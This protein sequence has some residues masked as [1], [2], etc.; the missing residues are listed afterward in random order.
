MSQETVHYAVEGRVASV[1]LGRPRYRNAQSWRM[2]DELDAALDHAQQ[3]QGVRAIIVT[4][5]GDHFSSGH[6]LGHLRAARGPRG[7]RCSPGGDRGVRRLSQVQPR[8]HAQVAQPAQADHRHGARLLHLRRLDDRGS[9]MDRRL[10]G[11]GAPGSWPAIRGVL[12][13]PLGHRT[14]A[15]PR[16]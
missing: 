12:L 13:H 11:A 2:L 16:S 6:D 8:S 5:E 15:R 10:R 9:A 7:A 14:R 1:T 4:G 3:D